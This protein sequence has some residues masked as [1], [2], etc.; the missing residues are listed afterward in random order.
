MFSRILAAI[1]DS[2]CADSALA[3]AIE[4]AAA[5]HS[6]LI[7]VRVVDPVEASAPV[8]D[9]YGAVQP[10]LAAIEENARDLIDR[11]TARAAAAGV[12]ADGRV[13]SGAP[14]AT[15]VD[16]AKR[17]RA[18]VVVLGSHGRKGLSRLIVGSVAEGVMREASCPTL[19]VHAHT[20]VAQ[21]AHAAP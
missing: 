17:E 19:V 12:A 20:A 15:L 11:A 21:P 4:L 9:P 8:M 13:L 6:K 5:N 16:L 2:E 7:I 18:D 3:L 14:V 10:Y 1:D